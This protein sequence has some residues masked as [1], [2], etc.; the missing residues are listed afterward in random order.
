MKLLYF[1]WVRS[2][3]GIGEEEVAP[4][5][6]VATIADL[7]AW[8]RKRGD[9]YEAAF[10]DLTSIRVA[11]NQEFAG[12]ETAVRAG[13]EVAFFPPITGGCGAAAGGEAP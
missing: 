10:A 7:I 6:E 2:R 5:P 11:V 12:P 13:D 1:A 4:P 9:G 8:L 3:I